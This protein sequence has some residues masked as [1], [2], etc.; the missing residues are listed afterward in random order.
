M[1]KQFNVGDWALVKSTEKIGVVSALCLSR[2][3][4]LVVFQDGTEDWFKAYELI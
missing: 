1:K 3:E 2:K 4:V